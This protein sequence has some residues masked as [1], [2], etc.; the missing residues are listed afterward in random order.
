MPRSTPISN[1]RAQPQT[2]WDR[3][4]RAH[5]ISDI[6]RAVDTRWR[7]AR[8]YWFAGT[9]AAF[10][11]LFLLDAW[12]NSAFSPVLPGLGVLVVL[13][14]VGPFLTMERWSRRPPRVETQERGIVRSKYALGAATTW[15]LLWLVFLV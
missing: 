14:I 11:L 2:W 12:F 6:E 3:R 15:F 10:P 9:I 13:W 4:H 8:R 5:A 7:I 1:S